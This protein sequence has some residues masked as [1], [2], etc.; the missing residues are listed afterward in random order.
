VI[1]RRA[2]SL[3][4]LILILFLGAEA[5]AE[6]TS[7]AGPV[8]R[9]NIV[10]IYTDD[11]GYGDL[12]IYGHHTIETPNLDQLAREG[13]RLTNYYAP[14]P[15]CSP[16]RAGLLTGRTPFRTGIRSWIPEGTNVQLEQRELTIATLLKREGYETFLGGKWHLN[17]G[18]GNQSQA[19]PEDHGFDQWLALHAFPIPHNRNPPNFYRNGEPLGEV[20]GYTGQ[21]TIDETIRW[22]EARDGS[23]PFFIYL[24]TVEPH[25]TIANPDEFNARYSEFTSGTPEP[26]VNGLPSPPVELLEARG[27]GEYYAHINYLDAQIGRFLKALDDGGHRDSTIVFFASDNGP[28]TTEWRNWWEVNVYGSTGGLRGRKGDLYEGGIREPAFVRWPGN[29]EPDTISDA[30]VSG[31]DLLPTLASIVGFDL[32]EDR[33]I[34]GEDF[35][36]VLRGESFARAQPLYWEFDDIAGHHYALRDG[37][38]KL[39]TD[40]NFENVELYNLAAEPFE[41]LDKSKAEP[42]IRNALL[43]KLK[44]IAESVHSDPLQPDWVQT[45]R[46]GA[47]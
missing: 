37:D 23:Q 24:A 32:P 40:E 27:P 43:G 26:I 38:W 13:I 21:I 17:A 1:Y 8:E 39:L 47:D 3:I 34:D 10:V 16:S 30:V 36:P 35:S 11:L 5:P 15:L 20:E 44:E 18:L 29:I 2:N 46:E 31:Y 12:G 14:A 42:K 9:P 7:V 45:N 41:L 6:E 4:T 22:L 25:S 33:P 19:Q 28:V